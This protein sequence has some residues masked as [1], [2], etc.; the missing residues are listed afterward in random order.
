MYYLKHINNKELNYYY[1]KIKGDAAYTST[2]ILHLSQCNDTVGGSNLLDLIF[3]VFSD[4]SVTP[5][6]PGLAEP[7]NYHPL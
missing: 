2:C 6:D 1:S 4:L 5:L 7:D 3:S